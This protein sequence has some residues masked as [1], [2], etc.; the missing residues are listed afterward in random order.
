MFG[1][2]VRRTG[3]WTLDLIRGG[4]VRAH[5]KE[6]KSSIENGDLNTKQLNLLLKHATATTEFYKDFDPNDINT[7]PIIS[8]QEIK[9]RW[10]ELYSSQYRGKPV[11]HMSTSGSTGTPFVIDWDM[12]KRSRQ[13]AELI[14]FNELA[15]Q[16]LGQPYIYFRVWNDRN[17]KSKREQ[18]MQNLTAI[19]I[20][21]LDDALLEEIRQRLKTRP[22][23]NSCLAYGSTY[24][25]IVKYLSS[26]G[27][28]PDMFH[29]NS[30][31]SGSD[32]LSMEIKKLIKQTVGCNVIDRYSNEE[33]GF[34]AQTGDF[35]DEFNVN[36]AGFRVELLEQESNK[37]VK[38]GELGRIVIT[39]LYNFAVPLIRYD[40]GDLAI[41]AEERDGWTTKLKTIQG[42]RVDVTYDTKGNLLTSHTWGVYM[43]KYDK[44][45]QFQFIQE[46]AKKYTL[47]VNGAEGFY[48]D[49]EFIEHLK[50]VLGDDAEITIEHVTGIPTLASGK[51]KRTICLYTPPTENSKHT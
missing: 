36:I 43:R 47:K 45:K 44:L 1:D 23:V 10:D 27:D 35:S 34:I 5:Y 28:T 29:V 9:E 24:E 2:L 51:F 26:K 25:H 46:D 7:F 17:R 38:I 16:R 15:G 12:N 8:K 22:Y 31:V 50:S 37:P 21:H 20:F 49:E 4:A 30:F 40:T 14:Y 33:N 32:A 41:K 42:R 13:L 19:D 39:D 18:W 6:T 3:F 11:H 48:S